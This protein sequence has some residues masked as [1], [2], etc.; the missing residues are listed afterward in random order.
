MS[1]KVIS[2]E[3]T[4]NDANT[5]EQLDTN[6]GGQPL[7]YISGMQQIIPGL[8]KELEKLSKGD[9][10]DVLVNP[11][12]AYG[13]YNDEAVQVVP[14]EQFSGIDLEAGMTLYGTGE[15]GETVQVIVKELKDDDVVVDYNHPMA[16]KTLMFSVVV[17]D[18]RD[19]TPEEIQVGVVG[20]IAATEGCGCGDSSCD[21]PEEPEHKDGGCCGGGHCS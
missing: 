17:L 4:L 19:A 14:K 1:N 6:V 3:Y 16:G 21:T 18:V 13:E 20:G 9:K 15:S 11:V 12:D 2:I 7:E 8:E 10:T 5:K